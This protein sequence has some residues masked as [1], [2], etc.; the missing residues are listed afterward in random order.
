MID[1][2]RDLPEFIGLIYDAAVEPT[3]WPMFLNRL[4]DMA[5]GAKSVMMLHDAST[6]SIQHPVT[7]R[8]EENWTTSYT[9][10]YVKLNKWTAAFAYF[11]VGRA[12]VVHEI[13]PRTVTLKSEFYQ[14]WL[15][16]QNLATGITVSI[17]KEKLRYMNFSVLSGEVEEE[18]QA[19]HASFLQTL[20]PHLRRAGQINR[21]IS[22]LTFASR[23][24]EQTFDHL[25]RGVVLLHAD[26]RSF[27]FNKQ[28]KH[29]L[30]L[31]DGLILH[32]D[33]RLGCQN[34]ELEDELYRTIFLAGKTAK[35]IGNAAGGIMAIPRRDE[36]MP[37]SLMITPM[38]A[39]AL[40]FR[41][42]EGAV[43]L[44]IV[45]RNKKPILSGASLRTVLGLTAAEARTAI[46]LAEG[47]SPEKIANDQGNTILTVRTH[48]RNAM[49]KTGISRLPELVALVL[50]CGSV[51]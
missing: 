44:F 22:D 10:Y 3:R 39:S 46:A 9:D 43:A 31:C 24:M 20:S 38:P 42:P 15:R 4:C 19:R 7:A 11:D 32:R 49:G 23:A 16:P 17:F 35:G 51:S 30:D 1:Q 37:W 21:Q 47:K 27:Y 40:D 28:A 45:D 5:P 14:D 6:R 48:L 18:A 41:H 33:G 13:V 50:R 25:D 2:E 29:D 26:G 36:L 34:Q 12:A 8:W